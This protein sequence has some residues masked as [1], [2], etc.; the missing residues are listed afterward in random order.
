MLDRALAGSIG[1]AIAA[2]GE[3]AGDP[4]PIDLIGAC[5]DA[6]PRIA[7]YARMEP[8]GDLPTPEWIGRGAWIDLNVEALAPVVEGPLLSAGGGLGPLGGAARSVAGTVAAAEAG[9]ITGLLSQRVLG[10]VEPGLLAGEGHVTRMVLVAPNLE[11]AAGKL[12]VDPADFVRWVAVHELTHAVQFSAVPW[13]KPELERL[14][15]DVIGAM[16]VRLDLRALLRLP[17]PD[18]VRALVDIVRRGDLLQAFA[19]EEAR[20]R[21]DRV[22]ALMGLIEGHAE[23]VMD[24]VGVDLV[25]DL[26]GL[27]LAMSERRRE[28]SPVEALIGRLLGVEAKLRQYEQG[29][30]FCDAV[31]EEGG[32]RALRLAWDSPDAVPTVDELTAPER[33]L[34]RV[35]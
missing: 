17:G 31:V 29:K 30:A 35:G 9:A 8:L 3:D 26:D 33:W 6:A 27:R 4:P 22:Q 14:I 20:A 2:G 28:R 5:E 21:M 15:Q 34:S 12:A 11:R 1:R 19:G 23:H 32:R 10:Q 13:L 24:A 7:A 18:D 25:D 16:S